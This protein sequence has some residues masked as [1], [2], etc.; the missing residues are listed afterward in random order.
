MLSPPFG[1]L[2]ERE[3]IRNMLEKR[4]DRIKIT[5]DVDTPQ[6]EGL[7]LQSIRQATII[8]CRLYHDV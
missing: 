2:R 6:P 8:V 3:R 4:T 1:G 7:E 5:S